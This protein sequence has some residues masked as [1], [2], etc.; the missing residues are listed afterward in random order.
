M[1]I[2]HTIHASKICEQVVVES[3]DT[4]VFVGFV[5]HASLI[6]SKY[7]MQVAANKMYDI[8]A[9]SASLRDA[10]SRGLIALHT[11]T[12]C[13]ITGKFRDKRKVPWVKAYLGATD[14]IIDYF[15]K[16][17]YLEFLKGLFAE[18]IAQAQKF[19]I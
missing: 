13:D 4:N 1:I 7:L 19:L 3:S 12:G 18:Y 15:V 5:A 8:K 16:F 2:Y 14:A 9:I 10:K 6:D 17:P 11:L